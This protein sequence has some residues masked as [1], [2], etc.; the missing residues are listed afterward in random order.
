MSKTDLEKNIKKALKFGKSLVGTGRGCSWKKFKPGKLMPPLWHTDEKISNK[1]IIIK[2]GTN[3]V[4]LAN[5][6]RNHLGLPRIMLNDKKC[7]YPEIGGTYHWFHYFKKIKKLKKI[8]LNKSYPTGTLLL[9]DYNPIDAGH[10]GVIYKENKKGV[11]FS[12]LLHSVGWNDGSGNRGV[13]IDDSVGKSHF[14]QYNG[15]TNKGHY[16]HICLPE[17]WLIKE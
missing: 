5:L 12:S 8:N 3:C 9:R 16:T 15:T 4:G 10:V 1:Q 17:D 11:L 14:A 6:I 13:K 2:K 7:K